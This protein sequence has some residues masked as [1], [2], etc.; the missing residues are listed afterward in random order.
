[1]GNKTYNVRKTSKVLL[2]TAPS[3]SSETLTLSPGETL[4]Q[5]SKQNYWLTDRRLSPVLE[6]DIDALFT[7]TGALRE[8]TELKVPGDIGESPHIPSQS[9][10][11]NNEVKIDSIK[12]KEIA[13]EYAGMFVCRVSIGNM[14]YEEYISSNELVDHINVYIREINTQNN[15]ED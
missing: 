7:N 13:G 2:Q 5:F 8:N 6:Q 1:M 3:E 11:D 12:R 9:M 15:Y 4:Q 14:S 10:I